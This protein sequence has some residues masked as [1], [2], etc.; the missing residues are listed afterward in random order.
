MIW[1]K[2]DVISISDF[3]RA[4]IEHVLQK[5]SVMEKKMKKG[6]SLMKGKILAALFFEPSTRTRLSFESAMHRLGGSVIGFSNEKSTSV[7]KGETIADTVKNVEGYADVIAMRHPIE[8]SARIASE[9]CSCPII[10]GGDGAN[11]HPTQTL[12]DLYTIKKEFGKVDGL[13]IGLIGDLKYGR[14]VHSLA[15]SM[16]KF[17]NVKLRFIAPEMLKMPEHITNEL[18]KNGF[19]VEETEELDLTGLDV[20]YCTRIQ[21][22]RFPDPAEYEKVKGI[23]II[24]NEIVGTMKNK[25]I[26]MH[27]LPRVNE[28][29]PEVDST[30]NARYFEQS[31]NGVPVRMA[32]ICLVSGVKI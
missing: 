13:N 1:K 12:L 27:P 19:E 5:A 10:N 6:L 28:I 30:P 3:S 24:D 17:K 16:L 15:N 4:E 20:A 2:T 31:R 18:K 22:E 29:K 21:G 8:G 7:K 25:S 23:Y 26:I 14:T 11:Q 32:L 9:V